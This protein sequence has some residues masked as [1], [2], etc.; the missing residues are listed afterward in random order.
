M[1]RLGMEEGEAIE[2]RMITAPSRTPRRRSRPQL[3]HPQA[4]ARIR[5]RDEQQREVIYGRRRDSPRRRGPS[6]SRC[7]RSPTACPTGSSTSRA[8]GD[9]AARIGLAR[10]SRRSSACRS[11]STCRSCRSPTRLASDM[12]RWAD[13]ARA[14]RDRARGD[15]KTRWPGARPTRSTTSVIPPSRLR[16][17]YRRIR[18]LW[19]EHLLSWTAS[20]EGIGLRG[21]AQS[22]PKRSRSTSAKGSGCSRRCIVR[23]D[24]A[25][26]VQTVFTVQCGAER[27]P[28]ASRNGGTAAG[29]TTHGGA[30][31]IAARWGGPRPAATA[32]GRSSQGGRNDPCACGAAEVE[33]P[34]VAAFGARS[35]TGRRAGARTRRVR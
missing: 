31:R 16:A 25:G 5:R 3:R 18:P 7:L 26:S 12:T 30:A 24:H 23:M 19:K 21:Y 9:G 13:A 1:T 29:A 27:G 14:A 4:S 11:P 2:H 22:R 34:R 17:R 32:R 35:A 10:R 28:R 6:P 8:T 33:V 15:P 20:E